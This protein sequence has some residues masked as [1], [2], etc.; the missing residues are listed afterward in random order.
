LVTEAPL[1]L[2]DEPTASLDTK[3]VEV[4]MKELQDLA[5]SGKAVAVVTHDLRLK[6]F[7]D[8]I[9][10]VDEGNI[11]DSPISDEFHF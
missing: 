6:P 8:R 5:A 3:S 11:S 1:L 4:V 7:A 9:V 2:C 10:Y